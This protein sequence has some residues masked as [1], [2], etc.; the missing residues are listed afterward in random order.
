MRNPFAPS[1]WRINREDALR[2]LALF[3]VI[4]MSGGN[5][6]FPRLPLA[7]LV[8]LIAIHSYGFLS[9][10]ISTRKT[11]IYAWLALVMIFAFLRVHHVDVSA[12]IIRL[13]NFVVTL[14]ILK[15]Y[16][17]DARKKFVDDI[18]VLILPMA[19][20]GL[21]T[22]FLAAVAPG[23]FSFVHIGAQRMFTIGGIFNY[24]V[25][26][27][28]ESG[29]PRP[30]AFFWEPGVFAAHLNILLFCMFVQNKKLIPIAVVFA[31]ILWTQSTTGIA[32]AVA[33]GGYFIFI[34][35]LKRRLKT[36]EVLLLV[37]AFVAAPLLILIAMDNVYSKFSGAGA[38]SFAARS[39]D[40]SVAVQVIEENPLIGIGFSQTAYMRYSGDTSL[41]VSALS[42]M[43]Q[44]GRFNT[45]GVMLILY[46]I[47][48]PLGLIYFVGLFR[49]S[50]VP[51]RLMFGAVTTTL[52]ASNP[53]SL[54]PYFLL[55]VF[56]GFSL[57]PSVGRDRGVSEIGKRR[58]DLNPALPS[59]LSQT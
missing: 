45:N 20:I 14:A 59:Q 31:A 46:S 9:A 53:L 57:R 54:T 38:G 44:D 23:L 51:Q 58:K 49:Q 11:L 33:Q 21:A 12:N 19:Y 4:L 3:A 17:G 29:L 40:F 55:F 50:L 48:L 52:L 13:V 6:A 30:M 37:T 43:D 16:W 41:D 56:N 7:M 25:P 5:L 36:R 2:R 18:V 27:V 32:L 1:V 28:L 10:R 42:V 34:S 26:L 39:F 15:I 35:M 24:G 22:G 47:G 8:L